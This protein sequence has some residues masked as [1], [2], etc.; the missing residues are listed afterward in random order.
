MS[1]CDSKDEHQCKISHVGAI[2]LVNIGV[3]SRHQG[4]IDPITE[5]WVCT[6]CGEEID[7][8]DVQCRGCAVHHNHNTEEAQDID[9]D[10]ENE[11]VIY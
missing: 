7:F 11:V 8:K 3:H 6:D 2:K 1:W 5:R 4:E 10:L 9:L